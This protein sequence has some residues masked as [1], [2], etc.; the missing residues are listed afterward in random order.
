MKII[1]TRLLSYMIKTI[2]I[3]VQEGKSLKIKIKYNREKMA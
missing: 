2:I 3:Y 1:F